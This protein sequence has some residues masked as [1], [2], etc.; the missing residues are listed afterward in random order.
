MKY[1][2]T[3]LKFSKFYTSQEIAY[4][5]YKMLYFW[6]V[7]KK[8]EKCKSCFEAFYLHIV[9]YVIGEVLGTI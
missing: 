5:K 9:F 4:T 7:L 1:A 2:F 8:K 6:S 3:V